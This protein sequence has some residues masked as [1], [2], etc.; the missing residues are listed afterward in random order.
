M[1]VTRG[2][3]EYRP[4]PHPMLTIGNFDGQHRGHLALLQAVVDTARAAK[5]GR[6]KGRAMVLTFDPHDGGEAGAV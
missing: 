3:T 5:G 4:S 1:K 6:A 2:L